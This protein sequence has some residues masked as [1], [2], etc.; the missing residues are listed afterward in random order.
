MDTAHATQGFEHAP[1]PGQELTGPQI[2]E[3]VAFLFDASVAP[4]RKAAFLRRLAEKGE[5]GREVIQFAQEMLKHSLIAG[6]DVTARFPLLMDIV[7]TGGDKLN[8][9]NVSTTSMLILAAAGIPV[10]KHGNRAVTGKSGAADVLEALGIQIALEPAALLDCISEVG[11]G[12]IFA[13]KY[14]PAFAAVAQA[15]SL[16]A[17]SG[18]KTVF[19]LLGPLLNPLHPTHRLIGVFSPDLI[20]LFADA[21]RELGAGKSWIFS[22]RIGATQWADELSTLGPNEL[23]EITS[24]TERRFGLDPGPLGFSQGRSEELVCLDVKHS[25]ETVVGILKGDIKG[26]RRDF[27]V[28]NAA[29][30]LFIADKVPGMTEGV[31]LACEIL[32]SGAAHGK[33]QQFIAW[34]KKHA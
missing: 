17:A 21:L 24:G 18:V 30:G 3:A 6:Q 13:R 4:E 19:N 11:V 27:A 8:L 14:H 28:L 22:G 12:F 7:G 9:F 31:H 25:T 29:A 15:R 34:H 2:K 1:D 10:A 32:D 20:P 16:L 5:T 26:V 23:A 33:L